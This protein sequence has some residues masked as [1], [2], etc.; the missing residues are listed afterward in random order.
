M[1]TTDAVSGTDAMSSTDAVS[2]TGSAS[3]VGSVSTTGSP[4]TAAVGQ[5]PA[6]GEQFG[7]TRGP[8]RAVIGQVAAVLR[9]FSVDGTHYTETWPDE[10]L[11]PMGCGIVL[12]PWPNR[13]EDGQWTAPDGSAQQ[14][15]ITEVSR[16][17]AIH[18]LLRNTVYRVVEQTPESV[19]LHA[20]VVPQHGWP[21]NLDTFV[22]YELA[23]AGLLVT[24]T[25]TNRGAE[26]AVFGVGA[27]PYLRVGDT[28]VE[29]LTLLVTGATRAVTDKRF[30]P[31]GF[32]PVGNQGADLRDGALLGEVSCND[33]LT[34][35]VAV[36]APGG[37][38]RF[39]HR[40]SGP[41]GRTLTLW[42]DPDF[43][44]AQ[45]YTPPD[46]P[47]H[48]SDRRLAVAVEPMTCC[49]NALRSGRDLLTVQ[50]GESWSA[51]WGL[52]PGD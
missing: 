26:P 19:T 52:T 39:E 43:R 17:T 2:G 8:A 36:A 27:H 20:E 32:E 21:F 42:T 22:R 18:G 16:N 49:A 38:E 14:L 37:G 13:T 30:L 15:D 9:E 7:L 47:G 46:F 51:R 41:D 24:H 40:L 23:D 28:P 6:S 48:G 33:A 1:S 35:F 3:S 5:R 11:P 10:Q 50:P 12:A 34:D 4:S 31:T 45:V 44:W 25:V 29:Q